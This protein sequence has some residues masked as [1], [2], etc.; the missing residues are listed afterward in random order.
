VPSSRGR[1]AW[2]LGLL[3]FLSV[4]IAG[5]GSSR[6]A[7]PRA[8]SLPSSYIPVPFGR[9]PHYRP[10][11]LSVGVALATPVARMACSTVSA[12]RYGAHIELFAHRRVVAIPA[13]IGVA[14]P[15]RRSGARVLGGRCSYPM[16]TT[17]PTGVIEL[18]PGP[19]RTLG[20]FFV[21]WGQPLSPTR[22]LS[23]HGRVRAFVAGRP[24]PGDPRA[25]PLSHHAQ[26]VLEFGGTL[27]PHTSYRFANGL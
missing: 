5:C 11:A 15:Q 22:L 3:F 12:Q 20:E 19:T 8:A 10:P 26:V 27:P 14:P 18:A 25:I 4:W 17:E 13:G 2:G 1:R 7:Q 21:L 23:F 24:W 16:R 6:H 9:G